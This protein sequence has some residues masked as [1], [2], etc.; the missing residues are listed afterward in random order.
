MY[1]D[2]NQLYSAWKKEH[3]RLDRMN[4]NLHSLRCDLLLKFKVADSFLNEQFYFPHN[5]D[6]RGRYAKV[7]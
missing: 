5:I 3:S 7:T 1:I 2:Y 6:F 4:R